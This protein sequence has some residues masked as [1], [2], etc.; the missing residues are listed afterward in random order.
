MVFR[1]SGKL[2]AAGLIVGSLLSLAGTTVIRSLLFG[3]KPYD[4][5][6]LAMCGTLLTM[7]ALMASYIPAR[8]AARLDPVTA[9]REE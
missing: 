5:M 8:R 3:V 4:L 6:A 1:E 2:L 7:V 9:L